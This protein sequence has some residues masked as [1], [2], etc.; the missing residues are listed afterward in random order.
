MNNTVVSVSITAPE[1]GGVI[2]TVS[3]CNDGKN[4]V[5]FVFILSDD[6]W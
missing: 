4:F 1:V 6:A 5:A 3:R 2:V